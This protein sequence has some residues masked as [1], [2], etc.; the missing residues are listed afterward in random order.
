MA[1]PFGCYSIITREPSL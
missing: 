1:H